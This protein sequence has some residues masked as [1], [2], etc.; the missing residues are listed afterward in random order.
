[1]SVKENRENFILEIPLDASAVEEFKP[2]Q[3]VKVALQFQDGTTQEQLVKFNEKGQ[4][5]VAFTLPQKP[6]ALHIVVGPGEASAEELLGMQTISLDLSSRHW[7]EQKRLVLP[8]VVISPYY[9][10][11]WLRRCR[12]FTIRGRVLCPDGNPVPGAKVCAYDIDYWWWWSTREMVGCSTTDATGSFEIKFRWCCGWWPWWWWRRK[13]WQLEPALAER[14]MPVLRQ[15]PKL[16]RLPVPG[17]KPDLAVF[18]ELLAGNAVPL[19]RPAPKID[20]AELDKL[21][22]RLLKRLPRV[23]EFERLYLWPWWPWHPW[24]D[25]HPDI[26]FKVTQNCQGQEQTILNEGYLDTRWDI[27]TSLDVNLVATENACCIHNPPPP[28]GNC[29]I[30]THA[31]DDQVNNIGGN[32]G[33]PASPPGYVNPGWVA[34]LGDRPYGGVV[35][36]SGIFG[37]TAS[38]A[39]YEFEWATGPAGPWNPMPPLAAG[40]V[41]RWFW[42]PALPAGPVG[43]HPVTFPFTPIGGQYVIESREHFEAANGAGSWG[44]TRFWTSNRDLLMNWLTENYFANG[45]YYLR[46]KSWDL[47]GSNLANPHILPLCDTGQDNGLVLA[48][49][50][51]VVGAAS[52]HPLGP[53]H[54]CGAGTVHL[55]TTE[56]DTDFLQ[57]RI[58]GAPAGA[59]AVVEARD[60]GTLDIDFLAHDPDKHLAYYTLVATFG[61]NQVIDLLSLPGI[62]LTSGSTAGGVPGAAQVGPD[63]GAALEQGAVSP[64]WA[65]GTVS[66]HIPDLRDAFP[67]SCCYQLELRAYKRTIYSCTDDV[68]SSAAHSNLSEYSLTV[69]V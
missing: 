11:W 38:V 14:I 35:P 29:L 8:P 63:Y 40:G 65:G 1:M 43:F 51:R 20:L 58:N 69:I 24:W 32:P 28:E 4:G 56:P 12:T 49:D 33:A 45:T 17:P 59:C 62:T 34:P 61:V 31:C 39:Y 23:A 47:A 68:T 36:I 25:C 19:R 41:T 64:G 18:D 3:P 44:L 42:G 48:I 7:G 55:C 6:G 37:A 57:V 16:N 15:V 52:G 5:T 27:P 21:G 13:V 50:N 67:V 10:A 60:G 30:I 2:D 26:I 54:P 46:V 22:E 66:L 53:A 9:W